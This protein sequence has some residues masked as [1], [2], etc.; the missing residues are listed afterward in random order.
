MLRNWANT[1]EIIVEY[2][3][4][5][6]R[7]RNN[8]TIVSDFINRIVL[9]VT[10]EKAINSEPGSFN[11]ITTIAKQ[12]FIKIIFGTADNRV[13]AVVKTFVVIEILNSAF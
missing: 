13:E 7:I 1:Y 8:I 5:F 3:A 11:I 2:V 6:F 9:T 12:S 4:N 10:V